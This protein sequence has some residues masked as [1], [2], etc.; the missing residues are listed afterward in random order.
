MSR[1]TLLTRG[2]RNSDTDDIFNAMFRSNLVYPTALI[3]RS[4]HS[5]ACL[6]HSLMLKPS[7]TRTLKL[8]LASLLVP[9]GL[10][11][12]LRRTA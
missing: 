7:Q 3:G 1:D 11:E 2:P 12:R 9:G 6:A 5:I 10:Y 4:L 8:L